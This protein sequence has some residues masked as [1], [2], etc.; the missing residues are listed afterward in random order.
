KS[1]ST[2]QAKPNA[3]PAQRPA[4]GVLQPDDDQRHRAVR[5]RMTL[6]V[7]PA[8]VIALMREVAATHILPRFRK[9]A[10]HE[11][12]EKAPG[13]LVTIADLEAERALTPALTALIPGSLVVGE[14]AVAH[15]PAIL[16]RLAGDD[17]VWVVD[18]VDGTQNFTKAVPCFAVIVALVV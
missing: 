5:I 4:V 7:D 6:A 16:D 15:D 14:E 2:R 8:A 11:I 13:N 9:L 18:P 12:H 17:P 10:A 3:K 1:P